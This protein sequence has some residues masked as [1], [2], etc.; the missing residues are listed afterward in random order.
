MKTFAFANRKGGVGKT[1]LALHFCHFLRERGAKVLLV[2]LDSQGNLSSTFGKSSC[3]ASLLFSKDSPELRIE[4][5]VQGTDPREFAIITSD[6]NLA[7]C[8]QFD[9][10]GKF[11]RVQKLLRAADKVWDYAIIDSPPA[12]DIFTINALV[13][14]DYLVIPSEYGDWSLRGIKEILRTVGE[15]REEGLNTTLRP[16]G[17]ALNKYKKSNVA[18]DTLAVIDEDWKNLKIDPVIPHSVKIDEA[19][20]HV[21]PIWKYAPGQAS[22]VAMKA[23]M[24]ELWKRSEGQA[25]KEV[26]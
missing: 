14:A 13:A 5:A 9:G 3:L 22:A 7:E 20:Q 26:A 16:I 21:V 15:I 6:S 11:S 17:I 18:D 8:M 2:D 1:T 4:P 12:L 10:V 25:M 19:N 24:N 23:V